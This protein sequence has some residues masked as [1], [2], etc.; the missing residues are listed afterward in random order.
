MYIETFVMK[1]I[2]PK[3]R[4]K[5]ETKSSFVQNSKKQKDEKRGGSVKGLAKIYIKIN[6]DIR[7]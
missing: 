3:E 6:L 2:I 4:K 1:E 7:L 5:T